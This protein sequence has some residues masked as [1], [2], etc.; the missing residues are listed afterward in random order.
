MSVTQWP[1]PIEDIPV[2]LHCLGWLYYDVSW[3][4]NPNCLNSLWCS[5]VPGM[6]S[7]LQVLVFSSVG[8]SSVRATICIWQLQ[9]CQLSVKTQISVAVKL[10][11]RGG[12]TDVYKEKVL[13]AQKRKEKKGSTGFS[14]ALNTCETYGVRSHAAIA[15]L[16]RVIVNTVTCYYSCR[17]ATGLNA[18]VLTHFCA[19]F[20]LRKSKCY[21]SFEFC[22]CGGGLNSHAWSWKNVFVTFDGLGW[23]DSSVCT[24]CMP[25]FFSVVTAERTQLGGLFAL[26]TYGPCSRQRLDILQ[27]AAFCGVCLRQWSCPWGYCDLA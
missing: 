19:M 10:T 23:P 5:A 7:V 8:N 9:V 20:Q 11:F 22:F 26:C 21:E 12:R 2:P 25:F 14:S 16:G 3:R 4:R 15:R 17:L 18:V 6:A 1:L 24:P 13:A 27:K